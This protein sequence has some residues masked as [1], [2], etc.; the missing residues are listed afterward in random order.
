MD[1]HTHTHRPITV[2]L[3]AHARRGLITTLPKW[4][5]ELS[6]YNHVYESQYI[7]RSVPLIDGLGHAIDSL[8]SL[9]REVSYTK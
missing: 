7:H 2:T 3:A 1:T 4:E 5:K 9:L 6:A 8:A